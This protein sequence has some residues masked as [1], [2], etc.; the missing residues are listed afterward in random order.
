MQ[1]VEALAVALEKGL[2]L[3]VV[4]NTSAYDAPSSLELMDG[5]V[6]IYMPDFKLWTPQASARC[7]SAH[8][9]AK[10]WIFVHAH[11]KVHSDKSITVSIASH[12]MS[13]ASSADAVTTCVDLIEVFIVG[14]RDCVQQLHCSIHALDEQ[15]S[16]MQS[17]LCNYNLC[18]QVCWCMIC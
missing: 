10:G 12:F 17:M 4:Y 13:I 16:C 11:L 5:L 9:P 1:V 8:V 2:N 7:C 18:E 15:C 14:T 3:P 6:D